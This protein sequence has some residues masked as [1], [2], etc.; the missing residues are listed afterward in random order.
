QALGGTGTVTFGLSSGPFV[1][2]LQLTSGAGTTLTVG[3]G[4]TIQTT[5]DT[6]EGG[7]IE[8][9]AGSLDLQ[10]TVRPSG[11]GVGISIS[12]TNWKNTAPITTSDAPLSLSGS[13]HNDGLLTVSGGT[14][15]VTQ[16][17]NYASGTLTGGTYQVSNTGILRLLGANIMTNAAT[18]RLDGPAAHLY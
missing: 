10:G 13:F 16:L 6:Q 1:N 14:L 7:N 5:S 2:R 4:V 9:G 11:V 17:T 8:A 15:L 18:I 12:G 3:P